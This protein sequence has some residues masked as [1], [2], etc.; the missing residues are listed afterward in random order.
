MRASGL[1]RRS[2]CACPAEGL[3]H[4]GHRTFGSP[5][6]GAS[7]SA[8]GGARRTSMSTRAIGGYSPSLLPTLARLKRIGKAHQQVWE[9][10]LIAYRGRHEARSM[11]KT[12][13][14]GSL[15]GIDA[16]TTDH[17]DDCAVRLSLDPR[18]T[19]LQT[20]DREGLAA[21]RTPTRCPR[22]PAGWAWF[23]TVGAA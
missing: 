18:R 1:G 5:G 11:A 12:A 21:V 23:P 7:R 20:P 19:M 16:D 2:G 15:I 4:R 14:S 13:V 3:A 17:G 9:S 6:P 8:P 10:E 22:I